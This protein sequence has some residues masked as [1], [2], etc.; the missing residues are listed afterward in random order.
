MNKKSGFTLI[1][2]LTVIL[3]IA[4]LMAIAVPSIMAISN[5]MKDRG[6]D[7]KIG[8]IEQAA[9]N[10]AQNNSNK[11]KSD[12]GGVCNSN[13]SVCECANGNTDCKYVFT[14]TV[15]RLIEVGA[16]E[17]EKNVDDNS[18]CDVSD[19]RDSSKCLDCVSITIKLD[20]DYKSASA[21]LN[22]DDIVD[23]KTVCN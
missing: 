15:D 4:L 11:I 7:S 17:T 1:E 12:L 19:P 23:G 8:A 22:K 10:Y 5:K 16:Y 3:I 20:D 13:S 21:Y 6:L 14:M 18:V 2:L 9:V